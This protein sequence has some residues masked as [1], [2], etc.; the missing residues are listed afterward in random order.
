MGSTAIHFQLW[1]RWKTACTFSL[2]WGDPLTLW[3]I[4][5]WTKDFVK[6]LSN[7]FLQRRTCQ[8]WVSTGQRQEVWL[9]N[10]N[11]WESSQGPLETPVK[12]VLSKR[13]MKHQLQWPLK[14]RSNVL[15]WD[16]KMSNYFNTF[17]FVEHYSTGPQHRKAVAFLPWSW[18]T[19]VQVITFNHFATC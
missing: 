17:Q 4:S 2:H 14:L 3:C 19:F 16:Y 11:N 8:G 1:W 10:Q 15:Y 7:C 6:R 5:F 18:N 12:K 13:H 9:Q